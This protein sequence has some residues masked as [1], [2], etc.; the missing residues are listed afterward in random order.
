MVMSL[1][2]NDDAEFPGAFPAK[3]RFGGDDRFFVSLATNRGTMW[4][5]KNEA[6]Q[7]TNWLKDAMMEDDKNGQ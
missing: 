7:L 6:S 1:I 4:F 2:L 3:V 5:T